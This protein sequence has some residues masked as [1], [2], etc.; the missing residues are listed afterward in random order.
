[1]VF[2]HSPP[3]CASWGQWLRLVHLS[4]LNT[5]N[6]SWHT[7]CLWQRRCHLFST[8]LP[9]PGLRCGIIS[10][11]CW[12][13]NWKHITTIWQIGTWIQVMYHFLYE[14]WKRQHTSL[15]FPC[16]GNIGK[17]VWCEGTIRRWK[18]LNPWVTEWRRNRP[19]YINIVA[20]PKF[21][22]LPTEVISYLSWF[23]N[24]VLNKCLLS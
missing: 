17:Y 5:Q 9:V 10:Q 18:T 6:S 20:P 19:T 14:A 23:I 15:I 3:D 13:L 16:H 2:A 12:E 1:M 24:T 4:V 8:L 7:R 11:P 21:T 22:G